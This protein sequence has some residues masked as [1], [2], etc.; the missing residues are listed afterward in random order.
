MCLC[1]GICLSVLHLYISIVVAETGLIA[2]EGLDVPVVISPL[3]TERGSA[4]CDMGR[5]IA[6]L[7]TRFP[8]L[9]FDV[10]RSQHTYIHII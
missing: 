3:L 1:L 2:T 4:P 9:N 7:R 5:P 10:R 6:T 8:Q